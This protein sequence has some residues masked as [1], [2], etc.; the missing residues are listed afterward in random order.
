MQ[1]TL[2]NREDKKKNK[3]KKASD[4]KITN[5]GV[6]KDGDYISAET[7]EDHTKKQSS[8]KVTGVVAV[9]V[10]LHN[11]CLVRCFTAVDTTSCQ[12]AK[13]AA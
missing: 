13:M 7:L 3:K 6:S 8:A 9:K 2:P 1:P 10:R 11:G 5:G 12:P 4:Q